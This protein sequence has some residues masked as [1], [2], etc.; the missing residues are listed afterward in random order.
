VGEDGLTAADGLDMAVDDF[1]RVRQIGN[2]LRLGG[3]LRV[4]RR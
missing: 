1:T 2:G 3:R 4:E